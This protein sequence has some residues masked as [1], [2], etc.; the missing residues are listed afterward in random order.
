MTRENPSSTA[1]TKSH[2]PLHPY[3]HPRQTWKSAL[4]ATKS[5][6]EF[7]STATPREPSTASATSPS[8]VARSRLAIVAWFCGGGKG[9]WFG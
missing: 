4:R 6:S 7:T 5:V 8:F 2:T 9:G 1:S 3:T